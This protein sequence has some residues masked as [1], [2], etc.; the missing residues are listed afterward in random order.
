MQIDFC[1]FFYQIHSQ[2]EKDG[3]TEKKKGERDKRGANSRRLFQ[4]A[5][6]L[7]QLLLHRMS[8]QRPRCQSP[9]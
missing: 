8:V 7:I 3:K 5:R 9:G 4:K 2:D 1:L 6:V